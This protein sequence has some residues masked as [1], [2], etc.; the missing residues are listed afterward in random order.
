MDAKLSL[1]A[2][3]AVFDTRVFLAGEFLLMLATGHALLQAQCVDARVLASNLAQRC[4]TA[5]RVYTPHAQY[6]LSQLQSGAVSAD[7]LAQLAMLPVQAAQDYTEQRAGATS[8]ASDRYVRF[9][10]LG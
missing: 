9:E 1:P 2:L 7:S 10:T 6:I 3:T 5:S 8:T 4:D